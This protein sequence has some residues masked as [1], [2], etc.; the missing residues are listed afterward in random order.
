MGAGLCLCGPTNA[1]VFKESELQGGASRSVGSK[2]RGSFL[3]AGKRRLRSGPG[4]S[5]EHEAGHCVS[6]AVY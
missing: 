6:M 3:P 4:L 1:C 5:P 2:V